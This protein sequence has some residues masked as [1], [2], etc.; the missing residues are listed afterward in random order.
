VPVIAMAV[1]EVLLVERCPVGVSI[2]GVLQ[3]VI[4]LGG[5]GGHA[6]VFELAQ[7]QNSVGHGGW[8]GTPNA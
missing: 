7:A 1:V 3:P 2:W 4:V 6:Q 5:A 8:G